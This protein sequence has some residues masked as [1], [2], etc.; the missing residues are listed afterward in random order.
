[1]QHK[2]CQ[3]LFF[4]SKKLLFNPFKIEA[5]DARLE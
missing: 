2:T 1:M 4:L 5:P 3:K